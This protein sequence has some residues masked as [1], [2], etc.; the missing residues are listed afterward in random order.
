[1]IYFKF[2]GK[3]IFLFCSA[4]AYCELDELRADWNAGHAEGVSGFLGILGL[5]TVESMEIA[6]LAAEI[7]N[8]AARAKRKYLYAE[9]CDAV[10]AEELQVLCNPADS[11]DVIR[12]IRAAINSGCST[13][14]EEDVEIDIVEL[15]LQKKTE[16]APQNAKSSTR[17]ALSDFLRLRR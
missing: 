2:N 16:S 4:G 15:E 17:R 3:K 5:M 14:D 1:M 12:A 6:F 11:I 10:T 7:L 8:R 13:G 9:D